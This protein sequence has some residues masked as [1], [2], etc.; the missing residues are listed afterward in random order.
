MPT[1]IITWSWEEAFDKFGFEDGDGSVM[2]DVVEAVLWDAGYSVTA[3]PWNSHN[4]VISS[5]KDATGN[6]IIPSTVKIGYGDPRSYLP[7]AIVA[8]LDFDPRTGDAATQA[9]SST[10][11]TPEHRRAFEA[12]LAGGTGFALVSCFVNA[13]PTAAIVAMTEAGNGDICIAPLFV[14]VTDDMTLT[15]HSGTPAHADAAMPDVRS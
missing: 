9:L 2:T 12:L 10:S 14:A 11:I 13:T 15:D 6:E 8:L 7:E 5:I 1:K 4:V 3:E